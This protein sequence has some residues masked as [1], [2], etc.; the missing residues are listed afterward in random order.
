L[1]HAGGIMTSHDGKDFLYGKEN[2][3][4]IAII[5]KRSANLRI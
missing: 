1:K 3:K 4:N 5:A 2:Y